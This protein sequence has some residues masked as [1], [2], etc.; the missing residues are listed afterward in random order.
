MVS[1]KPLSLSWESPSSQLCQLFRYSPCP[2]STQVSP[3]AEPEPTLVQLFM[4]SLLMHHLE[5][6]KGFA[7]LFVIVFPGPGTAPGV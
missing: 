2:P 5:D 7:L 1:A 3:E 4:E 6:G